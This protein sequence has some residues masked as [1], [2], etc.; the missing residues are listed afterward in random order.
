M[1]RDHRL[2]PT[3]LFLEMV[4]ILANDI[5]RDADALLREKD[6]AR[7]HAMWGDRG[8]LATAWER[9]CA[10]GIDEGFDDLEAK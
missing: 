9:L 2:D 1:C 5:Q 4:T 3:P 7:F 8:A 10:T 6:E